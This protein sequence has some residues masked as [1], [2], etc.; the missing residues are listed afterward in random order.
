M[1]LEFVQGGELFSAIHGNKIEGGFTEVHAKFYAD[2]FI[3]AL[4]TYV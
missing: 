1:L 3:L 2:G 4:G